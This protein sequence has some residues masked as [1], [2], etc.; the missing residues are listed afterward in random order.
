M[1][2]QVTFR[3]DKQV[4][5]TNTMVKGVTRGDVPPGEEVTW[6]EELKNIPPVQP[7]KLGGGCKNIEVKYLLTVSIANTVL[8]NEHVVQHIL[9]HFECVSS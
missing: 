1:F 9:L 5:R 2:Q 8:H 7:T 6:E 4:R 3:A